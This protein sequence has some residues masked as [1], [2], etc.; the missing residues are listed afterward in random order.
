[1]CRNLPLLYLRRNLST[2][3]ENWIETPGPSS[4]ELEESHSNRC[5]VSCHPVFW[6]EIKT[7]HPASFIGLGEFQLAEG[8]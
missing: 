8:M 4:S 2:A 5:L 6:G 7:E 3:E 1:M